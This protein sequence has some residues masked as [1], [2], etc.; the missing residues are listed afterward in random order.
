MLLLIFLIAIVVL[1]V[2]IGFILNWIW[3]AAFTADDN[4]EPSDNPCDLDDPEQRR[5][6]ERRYPPTKRS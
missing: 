6:F 1:S 3:S 4:P 2:S 5:E